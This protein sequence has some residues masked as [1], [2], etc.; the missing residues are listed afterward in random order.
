MEKQRLSATST[1]IRDRSAWC[2]VHCFLDAYALCV[3]G[4]VCGCVDRC[5][6]G[7]PP[8]SPAGS[9]HVADSTCMDGGQLLRTHGVDKAGDA[10]KSV[11]KG[12]TPVDETASAAVPMG[13]MCWLCVS[14]PNKSDN[15][16]Q[17][18]S[19]QT[20]WNERCRQGRRTSWRVKGCCRVKDAL[21]A[22]N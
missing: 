22:V 4:C 18:K 14:L 20:R 16:D 5:I 2:L 15:A 3:D 10:G 19:G 6:T 7:Q 13:E 9:G 8:G 1:A 12:G 21:K 11:V 17:A